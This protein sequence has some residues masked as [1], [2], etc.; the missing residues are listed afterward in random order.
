MSQP[1]STTA[2]TRAAVEAAAV[3][4]G[5]T[6]HSIVIKR[7][8]RPA[9]DI[10][11]EPDRYLYPASMIKTPLAIAALTLVQDGE[12]TLDQH[13]T[14]TASNMTAND[15]DSPMVTGYIAPLHQILELMITHSDNVA[16]NMMF[17]IVGRER[18][19]RMVQEQYGL[20]H[21]GF[22][23][24]LS[25]SEPLIVDPLWDK[26]HRNAHSAGDAAIVFEMI[27]REQV[28]FAFM[29]REIL[30][31]QS[32][33]NKL[34]AGLNPGD[35]YAHKTGDTGEVTHDAGILD[36]EKGAAYV[37]AVYTGLESTDANNARFAPFMSSINSLL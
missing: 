14:V 22:Y 33:N 27:A 13:F 23:R 1:S 2:L 29:L 21:T 32:F 7:L 16:T 4:A 12:I 20:T 15:K 37:I 18:A 31:R 17:D 36:T 25:G 8:D 28:P 3:K 19:T 5:L 34:S 26:V 6:P 30:A 11:I 10:Q 35:H 24:K 9:P